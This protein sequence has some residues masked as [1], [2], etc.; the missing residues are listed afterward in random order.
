MILCVKDA[1]YENTDLSLQPPQYL[2]CSEKQS[3]SLQHFSGVLQLPLKFVSFVLQLFYFIV[4]E[5]VSNVHNKIS[6]DTIHVTWCGYNSI[7][8]FVAIMNTFFYLEK[9]QHRNIKNIKDF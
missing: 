1:L 9:K 5:E 6:I 7:H 3:K 2:S 8:I 4:C